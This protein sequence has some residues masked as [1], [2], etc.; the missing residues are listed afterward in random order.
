MDRL[1]RDQRLI[2]IGAQHR[3]VPRSRA[4][5]W[6]SVSARLRIA[7]VDS[8]RRIAARRRPGRITY[9]LL[10]AD[11]HRSR[12]HGGLAPPPPVA[13]RAIPNSRVRS[14]ADHPRLGAR[15]DRDGEQPGATRRLSGTCVVSGTTRSDGP[16]SII[17]ASSAGATPQR[18]G[19]ELGLPRPAEP[20]RHKAAPW[21]TGPVTSPRA[22]PSRTSV[23]RRF[24]RVPRRLRARP[25]SVRAG[26]A[27]VLAFA[28]QPCTG[29]A[30]DRMPAIA[31]SAPIRPITSTGPVEGRRIADRRRRAAGSCSLAARATPCR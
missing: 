9:E 24:E 11:R 25:R 12:R 14:A 1:D 27:I 4:R 5:G 23:G 17:T 19:D 13:A 30:P 20:D 3:V 6:N 16:A 2:V 10:A 26:L 18:V 31:R 28:D 29:K 7:D 15:S 21:L 8:R 22:A